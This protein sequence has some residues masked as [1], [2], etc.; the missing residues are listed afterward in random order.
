MVSGVA[1]SVLS[2]LIQHVAYWRPH[3]CLSA[4]LSSSAPGSLLRAASLA[5]RHGHAA[6]AKA[7]AR[8]KLTPAELGPSTGAGMK[9][10][11]LQ[12][13]A[14]QA[15]KGHSSPGQAGS[16]RTIQS[17]QLSESFR[18]A[19][20]AL[21]HHLEYRG[22]SGSLGSPSSSPSSDY[23]A[24]VES[25][26]VS[27]ARRVLK[28]SP[29]EQRSQ[30]QQQKRAKRPQ[31]LKQKQKAPFSKLRPTAADSDWDTASVSSLSDESQANM[32]G[33][34]TPLPH[35]RAAVSPAAA[36]GTVSHQDPP[37]SPEAAS[38]STLI[39]YRPT[40]DSSQPRVV[41]NITVVDD[42]PFT[43]AKA[44]QS[45]ALAK[46]GS[47]Q[48]HAAPLRR[49]SDLQVPQAN[50]H[51]SDGS[52]PTSPFASASSQKGEQA[53][54]RAT[55]GVTT[56]SPPPSI[57]SQDVGAPSPHVSRELFPAATA[58]AQA[59]DGGL[60]M[61]AKQPPSAA[62]DSSQME[63]EP[64][65]SFPGTSELLVPDQQAAAKASGT[66]AAASATTAVSPPPPPPPPPPL[67]QN[68]VRAQ[69]IPAPPPPPPPPPGAPQRAISTPAP[70]PPP[71]PPPRPQGPARTVSAPAPPP[72]PPPPL[73]ARQAGTTAP[74]PPPPPPPGGRAPP[75][76]P[77][78]PPLPP[79]AKPPPPAPL[80]P[81]M[82]P[83]H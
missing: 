57:D 17:P 2:V 44:P 25:G 47:A 75:A 73:A 27:A 21:Q 13:A 38:T 14:H 40:T 51:V 7:V 49:P 43:D 29:S 80:P 16:A 32:P 65:A 30:Q 1:F 79:G 83:E 71:P 4:P 18:E 31:E 67:P 72:P 76:A 28:L 50:G 63:P 48:R 53:G 41:V 64:S 68:A 20:T 77:P 33:P 42:T 10:L 15:A 6:L 11:N 62:R 46:P 5:R 9:R 8:Y 23:E 24:S 54:A 45:P 52:M 26:P 60:S 74:P 66:A 78:P 34:H 3:A 36:N 12:N 35:P 82:Q 70:P 81:G 37:S 59:A 61:R 58:A 55:A 39:S 56:T 19:R 69:S 22:S